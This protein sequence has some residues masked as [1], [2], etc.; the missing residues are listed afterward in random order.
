MLELKDK[1]APVP[2]K[3]ASER[4]D[5]SRA[6][7]PSNAELLSGALTRLGY[8]ANEAERVIQQLGPRVEAE[9]VQ[10]LVRD[11]LVLLAR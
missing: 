9:P 7:G 6:A 10:A 5:P 4:R 2:R 3:A 11:A 8:R 1:L